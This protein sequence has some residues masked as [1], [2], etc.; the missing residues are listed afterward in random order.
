M[1]RDK[2][3]Q[4]ARYAIEMVRHLAFCLIRLMRSNRAK[5]RFV[6]AE[7]T[8]GPSRLRQKRPANSLK[9]SSDRIE[10]LAN[11]PKTQ[12]LSQLAMKSGVEFMETLE[13]PAGDGGHLVG[14]VLTK[15]SNRIVRHV[16]RADPDNLYLQCTPHQHPLPHILKVDLGH[17]RAALRLNHY[18]PLKS[19]PIDRGRYG[20]S[21]YFENC[22]PLVL[23]DWGVRRE[24]T[25]NDGTLER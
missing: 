13:I 21:R 16:G 10:D 20:E 8:L 25:R 7:G 22:T 4:L 6:L 19:E 5:Y 1:F 3:L 14:E 15:R 9:M 17:V 2:G 18:K 12:A 24:R 23:V 11:P